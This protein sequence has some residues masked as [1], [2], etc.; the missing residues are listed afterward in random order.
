MKSIETFKT[1]SAREVKLNYIITAPDNY[2]PENESLPMIVFLHGAG[3]RGNDP[4]LLRRYGISKIFSA[5][6]QYKGMRTVTLSPQLTDSNITW[7]HV[8]D[9]LM[10]LIEIIAEKYNINR[11][12]ITL[13]GVSMGGFGTWEMGM[14]Y[15]DFF[16]ALA[17]ICGG[18]MC[19]RAGEIARAGIPVRAFHGADDNIVLPSYSSDMVNA[20]NAHGGNAS[21][22]IYEGIAHDVWNTVYEQTDVIEWLYN[23]S[24]PEKQ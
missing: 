12:R 11:D 2:D 22:T 17:P 14:L 9:E 7:N 3:E 18:G 6:P 10:Q 1:S 15:P 24:K 20:V 5:D 13:T 21:L 8:T 4:E 19:W 23:S 16:A